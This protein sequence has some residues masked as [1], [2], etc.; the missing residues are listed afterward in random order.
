MFSSLTR[1][2]SSGHPSWSAAPPSAPRVAR[3]QG[4]FAPRRAGSSCHCPW[5]V[6]MTLRMHQLRPYPNFKTGV[7]PESETEH[8]DSI[9][10]NI[11]D[12]HR[13]ATDFWSGKALFDHCEFHATFD[14]MNGRTF[15]EWQRSTA[16]DC[17]MSLYHYGRLI[18]GIDES[19]GHCPVLQSLIDTQAKRGARKKFER[20]FPDYISMRHAL[21]HSAERASTREKFK[22]H[23]KKGATT[24]SINPNLAIRTFS[25]DDLTLL[26]DNIFGTTFSSMWGGKMVA[27]EI[28]DQTGTILDE[29]TDAYWRAFS[30]IIDPN[31]EPPPTITVSSQPSLQP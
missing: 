15:A 2:A 19:L 25:D 9:R 11:G 13:R 21:A 31:P 5:A 23:A 22:R 6:S 29:I 1:L 3:P 20:A 28:S 12:L 10:G 18:E 16:R 30:A 4:A 7:L 27:C 26:G 8:A 24:I 14:H 17:A